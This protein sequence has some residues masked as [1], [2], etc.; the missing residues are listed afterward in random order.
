MALLNYL[1]QITETEEDALRLVV[2]ILACYPLAIIYRTFIYKMPERLQHWFFIITGI[3]LYLFFCGLAIFHTIFSII[4]AYLIIN[5]IS[6]T[7]LSVAAAHFFF[8]GHLLIG[9]W[10]VESSTYD[11]SWTTPFCIMT[12]RMT[13]L[14]MDVYDGHQKNVKT[15]PEQLKTA[16]FDK[17]NLIE[18]AAYSLCFAGTLTGPLLSLKHFRAF[19]QGQYLDKD[20]NEVRESRHV[21]Y[22]GYLDV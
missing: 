17:P 3:L 12:L 18:I 21:L 9:I 5:F 2:S 13:A 16:I 20:K 10:F 8:L 1:S 11:I 6:G 15:K 7:T 4:I 19:V 22:V 14:V